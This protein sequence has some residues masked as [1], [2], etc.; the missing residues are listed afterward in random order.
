[1]DIHDKVVFSW[2]R[3]D[4]FGQYL[5]SAIFID[6]LY[7]IAFDVV[8]F[9]KVFVVSVDCYYHFLAVYLLVCE[10]GGWG[11]QGGVY[12]RSYD[13]IWGFLGFLFCL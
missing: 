9:F 4:F 13:V 3:Y 10:V 12:V 8:V 7:A 1:M 2:R 11:L 6:F 5:E